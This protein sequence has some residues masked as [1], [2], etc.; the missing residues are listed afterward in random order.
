M[1][2]KRVLKSFGE[3][4]Q[5]HESV[6]WKWKKQEKQR[7]CKNVIDGRKHFIGRL[8]KTGENDW[9]KLWVNDSG[10]YEGTISLVNR[11]MSP[12]GMVFRVWAHE[13]APL[14]S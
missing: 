12:K 1:H 4:P 9:G 5:A 7:V 3:L 13:R 14:N 2:K 11:W 8:Q 6:Q 10:H